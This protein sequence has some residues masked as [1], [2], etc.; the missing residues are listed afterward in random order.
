MR[1]PQLPLLGMAIVRGR[2]MTPTLYDGDRLL[3]ATE[4][5]LVLGGSQWCGSP[6]V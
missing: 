2:S 6:T 5:P 1:P 3:V 4:P